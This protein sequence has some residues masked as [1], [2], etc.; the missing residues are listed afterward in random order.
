MKKNMGLTDSIF[1]IILA[2]V[3]GILYFTKTIDG[4]VA[5]ILMVLAV[6]FLLTSLISFCPLYTVFGFNTCKT[7]S[8]VS[9]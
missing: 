6:V 3:I 2:V 7:K 1:R 9:N 8:D 5:L 4:T